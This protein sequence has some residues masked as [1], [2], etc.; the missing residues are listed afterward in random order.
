MPLRRRILRVTFKMASGDVVLDESVDI[1]VQIHKGALEPQNTASIEIS[2]LTQNLR[3][4]LMS[5]FTAYNRRAIKNNQA[6]YDGKD[7][8][9]VNVM[10]EAGYD[11]GEK[12]QSSI[13]FNGQVV[14]ASPSSYPPNLSLRMECYSQQIDRISWKTQPTPPGMNFEQYVQW[15]GGQMKVSRTICDTSRNNVMMGDN[16]SGSTHTIGALLI[17]IQNAYNPDVVAYV[18][19]N[20]LIVRDID[21]VVDVAGHVT[22]DEFIGT[23]I[24]SQWGVQFQTLFNQ[25]LGLTCAVKLNSDMNPSLNHEFVVVSVYYQLASRETSFYCR[26]YACPP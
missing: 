11:D 3:L 1:K 14:E 26:V 19:N 2:N 13:I 5:Q 16:M 4:Q 23:P 7:N 22:I 18:D 20:V 17:D 10:V 9:Y 12:K 6:T 25:E 15:V 21:R 24:W 8:P